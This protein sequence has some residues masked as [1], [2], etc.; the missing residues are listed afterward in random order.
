MFLTQRQQAVSVNPT[1]FIH[2]VNTGDTSQNSAGSSFKAQIS[3]I[4]DL[5]SDCC[6]TGGTVVNGTLTFQNSAGN[7][8]FSVT[9]FAFTGGSGNCVNNLYVNNIFPCVTNIVIQP[10]SSGNTY[11]GLYS[12]FTV[13]HTSNPG[14]TRIGLN[15]NSPQYTFDM[16]S[17]DGRSR[18]FYDEDPGGLHT[19]TLSGDSNLVTVVGAFSD[20]SGSVGLTL[21]IR[22]SGNTTY[23]KIGAQ[24][25]TCLYSS[26]NARGLN[27]ITQYA[28]G[29]GPFPEYIRFYAGTDV[30]AANGQ[31]HIHIDGDGTNQGFIGIGQGNTNPTSLV[32]ISGSTGYEQLRLRTAYVPTS[33]ADTNGEIG[34]ICWG[35]DGSSNSFIYVR[36]N[37]G[38]RRAQLTPVP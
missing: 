12:G 19:I 34:D 11:F 21:N 4:F 37:L 36:T 15:T 2:I 14:S 26:T 30:E 9:G 10:L 38:W 18:Y 17:Y 16:Y 32:D 1:D 35:T 25:D 20:A 24:G 6:L 22:G 7:N 28:A 27:I 29:A 33:A 13:D 8:A 5:T 23:E 3:Q 31:P